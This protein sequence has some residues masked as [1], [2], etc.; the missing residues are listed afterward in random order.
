MVEPRSGV[1]G[2]WDEVILNESVSRHLWR[3]NVERTVGDDGVHVVELELW[4]EIPDCAPIAVE[5]VP[6]ATSVALHWDTPAPLKVKDFEIYRDGVRVGTTP[7]SMRYYTDY[8]LQP[9]WGYSYQIVVLGE[10][11][12][13]RGRSAPHLVRT[14]SWMAI[15]TEYRAL[16][17]YYNPR[18]WKDGR[19]ITVRE[20]YG[21]R[22]VDN[23]CQEFISLLDRASGGQVRFSVVDRFELDE[24]PR[25]TNP[26]MP[27]TAE[28]YDQYRSE[29]F[30]S[31]G[32]READYFAIC[33]D[34]R[35][36]INPR[37][38]VGDVDAIWVFA[39]DGTGFWET[40]M[41]GRGAY[42]INGRPQPNVRCSKRFVIYGFGM[43]AHQGVGFMCENT[44]HMAENIMARRI[45]MAWPRTHAV[46]GWNTLDLTQPGRSPVIRLQN[47]WEYFITSDA[48]H[49]DVQHVAPRQSQAGLS[50]YPPTACNNYGWSAA[51]H[52][53]SGSE[54]E[55]FQT[56]GGQW[57]HEDGTF[58]VE[59]GP[60]HKA[61]LYL[62]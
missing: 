49:W 14:T 18:I 7:N 4:T 35:F 16:V 60:G 8:G 10:D 50:H 21:C 44:A 31:S 29:G 33:N 1:D 43:A 9:G 23:L 61:I 28:N 53:F 56:Y 58:S 26:A 30:R 15:K 12:I 41:A 37:V 40:V 45:A 38:E 20:A 36:Q 17:L 32:D 52:N 39:P 11:G 48:M 51:L 5:A 6:D 19:L 55:W 54:L 13:P 57:R 25:D 62:G 34:P 22:D 59:A 27:F 3:F 46:T 24:F 2:R 47:D 42:W